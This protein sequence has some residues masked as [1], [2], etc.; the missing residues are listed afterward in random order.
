MGRLVRRRH[1][2]GPDPAE[3]G[4]PEAP[5]PF[6][7]TRDVIEALAADTQR[8]AL[9]FVDAQGV[10][11]KRTF[12]EIAGAAGR[13][14]ALL[15]SRGLM[16]GDRVV[17]LLDASPTWPAVLLGALKA[18]LVVVPCP[19][20]ASNDEL[21]LRL[22]HSDARLLIVDGE[23]AASLAPLDAVVEVLAC[24]AVASELRGLSAAQPTDETTVED[25]AMIL[26]PAGAVDAHLSHGGTR[27]ALELVEHGLD[28]LPGDLVWCA[29]ET[30]S[31]T[32]LWNALLVP[33]AAGAAT[34]IHDGAFDPR[35]R[36]ELIQRLG[37]TVLR[38]EPDEYRQLVDLPTQNGELDGLR[39]AVSFGS[40]LDPDLAE[41]FHAL[42]GIT[43]E[44]ELEDGM[45]VDLEPR[46]GV[47]SGLD[48]AL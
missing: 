41:A 2:R 34:V 30:G 7:F 15:R 23:R 16:P 42:C 18:G 43:I 5:E 28:I 48:E 32:W 13:W 25:L 31:S 17:A 44:E 46:T 10:I 3:T 37:V 47:A 35:Q 4:G 27:G 6:N 24:D 45:L 33:W 21:E 29:A 9:R 20:A 19:E 36:A 38:Q 11:D 8:R 26:S 12:H 1:V 40:P 22:R 14:S 39:R